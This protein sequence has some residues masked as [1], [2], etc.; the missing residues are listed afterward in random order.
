MQQYANHQTAT[1]P[2]HAARAALSVTYQDGLGGQI[3][4][5]EPGDAHAPLRFRMILPQGFGPPAPECHPTQREDFYV[6]RG[7]LD[8]GKIAG[9]RVVLSSGDS[10]TLPAGVYHLP[11]NAGSG[12]LEFE[13]TLT[14]GLDAADMFAALYVATRDNVGLGRFVRIAMIFRRHAKTISFRFPVR[15]VM[16]VV[17]VL[18]ELLGVSVP[19]TSPSPETRT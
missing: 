13:S 5:L 14:P 16:G 12:E 7:T 2:E 11:A 19:R 4:I 18:G 8:L 1:T 6:L 15:A 10:Y 17:A 3:S 9:S